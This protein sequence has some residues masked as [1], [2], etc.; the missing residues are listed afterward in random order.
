MIVSVS[1]RTDVP[2]FYTE[3]FMNRIRAG[4]CSVPNP[5]NPAQVSRVSLAPED[6]D[7]L[8]FWTRNPRPLLD[9][10]PELEA[11]RYRSVFLYTILGYPRE[12]DPGSPPLET[13]LKTFRELSRTIGPGRMAWRYD[14]IL[15]TNAT[16]VPYH[17]ERYREIAEALEGF[18][19]RSIVSIARIYRK[20]QRRLDRLAARGIRLLPAGEESF[21]H[22]LPR[23]AE[24]AHGCG[25]SIQ[26]C[27]PEIDVEHFGIE[28]GSCID[29]PWLSR[30][31]GL[32][33]DT[34]KD[35]G[36]RKQCGC[37]PS[38]DI[39]MYDSC[40]TGCAYCYATSDF[41]RAKANHAAHDSRAP[42]LLPLR[43]GPGG[44]KE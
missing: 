43:N 22:L 34:G 27:A 40:L 5:F 28:R 1:R 32:D 37:A 6:V 23:L 26:A 19:H 18:T 41:E 10:L 2:S 11:R 17:L 38:R 8:V 13:A 39:G 24:T 30:L 33:F 29:G 44:R 21:S 12:I 4:W 31:F 14:P 20:L 9:F 7:V 42:S 16:G 25:M 35:A 36:Q 15:L 3:W